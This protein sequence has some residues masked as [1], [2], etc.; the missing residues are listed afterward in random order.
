MGGVGGMAGAF[1]SS[2]IGEEIN[3]APMGTD[4]DQETVDRAIAQKE[5]PYGGE[6]APYNFTFD[7]GQ[8]ADI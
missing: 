5:N 6:D 3:Q 1:L 4:Y 8:G 7:S 2:K